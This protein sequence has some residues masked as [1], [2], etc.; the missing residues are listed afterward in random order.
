MFSGQTMP[1]QPLPSEATVL[2]VVK[3]NPSAIG[4]LGQEPGD[5]GVRVV[6]VLKESK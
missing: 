4:Y 2:D 1:P 3:R 5:A 6:L